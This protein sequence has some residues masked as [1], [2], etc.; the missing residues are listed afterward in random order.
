[1]IRTLHATTV[2]P[3]IGA[4]KVQQQPGLQQSLQLV[5]PPS[6]PLIAG[7]SV[8][9]MTSEGP[10]SPPLFD[11]AHS[12]S[13]QGEEGDEPSINWDSVEN[14]I[15]TEWLSDLPSQHV[16]FLLQSRAV[17]TPATRQTL[18]DGTPIFMAML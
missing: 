11:G 8:F 7:P 4:P 3:A 12:V 17:H 1:M 6:A 18:P 9:T 15:N 2:T 5:S 13:L 10:Q 14:L 16:D